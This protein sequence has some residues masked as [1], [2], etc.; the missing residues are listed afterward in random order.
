MRLQY[1]RVTHSSVTVVQLFLSFLQWLSFSFLRPLRN[2]DCCTHLPSLCGALRLLHSFFPG[3]VRFVID[4][5]QIFLLQHHD[6]MKTN[7][8]LWLLSRAYALQSYLKLIATLSADLASQFARQGISSITVS[9][10]PCYLKFL[11]TSAFALPSFSGAA[12]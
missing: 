1:Y 2:Q 12:L 5:Y 11:A 9:Q 8:F 4:T 7:R 3:I 6:L 10:L